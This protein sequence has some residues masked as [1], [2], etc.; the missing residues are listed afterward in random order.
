[1]GGANGEE[2]CHSGDAFVYFGVG[3]CCVEEETVCAKDAFE[4]WGLS[5]RVKVGETRS[6][7]VG[8]GDRDGGRG[9]CS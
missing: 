9:G 2:V 7:G 3:G 4:V 8:G 5:E 1:M 6:N